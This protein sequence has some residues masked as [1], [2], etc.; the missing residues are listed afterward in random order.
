VELYHQG[1]L[2]LP[3]RNIATMFPGMLNYLKVGLY[4]SDT[5]SQVGVVY[6]DGWVMGRSLADVL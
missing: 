2:V 4:R 5:V 6:H 3:K 1:Q